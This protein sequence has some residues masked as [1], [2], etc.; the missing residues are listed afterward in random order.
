MNKID[1]KGFRMN[2]DRV[3]HH[4]KFSSGHVPHYIYDFHD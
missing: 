4:A 3:D 1:I 2:S